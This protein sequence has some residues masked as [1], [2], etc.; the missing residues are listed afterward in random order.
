MKIIYTHSSDKKDIFQVE[1]LTL[2]M[3]IIYTHSSDKEDIFQVEILTHSSE[4][5]KE[6]RVKFR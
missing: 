5:C 6:K 1:I 4:E 3:K 2:K